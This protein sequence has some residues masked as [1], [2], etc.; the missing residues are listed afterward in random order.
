MSKPVPRFFDSDV[1]PPR[2]GWS[3]VIEGNTFP[4][5]G[6]AGSEGDTLMAVKAWR[7]NNGTYT[8]DGDIMRELWDYWRSREPERAVSVPAPPAPRRREPTGFRGAHLWI[9]LHRWALRGGPGGKRWLEIFANQVTCDE[10]RRHWITLITENPPPLDDGPD[11]LF[12]WSVD[13]HNDVNRV[14]GKRE[15][16]EPAA[17]KLYQP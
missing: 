6:S 7:Q 9:E 12:R 13:R 4:E 14:L 2:G 16:P 8:S 15:L 1:R 10:C 5:S 3:A 17:R 11:A